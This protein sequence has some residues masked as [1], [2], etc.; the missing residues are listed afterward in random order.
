M[1]K[2]NYYPGDEQ[3]DPELL[4]QLDQA[5]E[6]GKEKIAAKRQASAKKIK[7]IKIVPKKNDNGKPL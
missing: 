6:E 7:L 3:E 2:E 5:V 4:M 1:K